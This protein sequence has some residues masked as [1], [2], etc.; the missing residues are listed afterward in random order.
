MTNPERVA[1]GQHHITDTNTVVVVESDLPKIRQIDFQDSQI[2]FRIDPHQP[3]LCMP[4]VRQTDFNR[5]GRHNHVVVGQ[6]M[7]IV[8]HDHARTQVGGLF[9]LGETG[10]LLQELLQ[11]RVR[12][13]RQQ[14]HINVFACKNV[15]H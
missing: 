12:W 3:G 2:T 13:N 7:T 4:P 9:T 5:I 11:M 15:H 14:R 8:T 6:N 1:N 10:E